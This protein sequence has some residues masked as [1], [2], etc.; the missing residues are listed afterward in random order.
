[1]KSVNI[2]VFE[3]HLIYYQTFYYIYNRLTDEWPTHSLVMLLS[4]CAASLAIRGGVVVVVLMRLQYAL[5]K[6]F[7]ASM[8]V[9]VQLVTILANRKLLVVIDGY[10]DSAR[11]DGFILSVVELSDVRVSEGLLGRQSAGRVELKQIAE[12]VERVVRSRGEHV[13]QTSGLGG[14]Q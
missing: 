4:G 9:R 3:L 6:L 12:Q 2:D 7:F 5:A 14:R 10:V 11:A 1:M 13:T 8:D